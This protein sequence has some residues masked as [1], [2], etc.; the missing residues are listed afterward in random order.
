MA[1]NPVSHTEQPI[2]LLT[3]RTLPFD[4]PVQSATAIFQ[5]FQLAQVP[6]DVT[7]VSKEAAS[8]CLMPDT[9]P[10]DILVSATIDPSVLE[11]NGISKVNLDLTSAFLQ[12][13]LANTEEEDIVDQEFR[14]LETGAVNLELSNL[15]R[16]W[17]QET[18]DA[19]AQALDQQ[20]IPKDWNISFMTIQSNPMQILHSKIQATVPA[21]SVIYD[22][23]STVWHID[24]GATSH[25]CTQRSMFKE[26]QRIE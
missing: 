14:Q 1:R 4:V 13:D 9:L 7:L 21:N 3:I 8:F 26:Y 19:I 17:S 12:E 6:E 2:N 22:H 25:I 23:L 18:E 5:N 24:S 11:F 10:E 20:E 16:H 15:D